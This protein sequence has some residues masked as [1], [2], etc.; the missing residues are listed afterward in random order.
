MTPEEK[1]H[2]ADGF[3]KLYLSMGLGSLPKRE[4]DLYVFHHLIHSSEYR[5][6]SNYELANAFGVPESR[7]KTLRLNAALRHED[8]NPHAVLSRIVERLVYSEKFASLTEGKIEISLEDPIEK[9]EL[10][11]FLKS[12]GHYAEYTLN[13]EVLKITP[14]RLLE[15]IMEHVE[16]ANAE[17]DQIV[18]THIT[19]RGMSARILSNAPSL[20]QKLDKLRTENL[21]IDTLKTLIG[22]GFRL[23]TAA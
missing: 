20:K 12:R 6:K 11:N 22:V 4:I 18:R 5:G 15:L 13:S 17:F 19:D 23:L 14:I 3:L 21:N 9:R 2:F 8:I 7:I 16:N 1:E 10:E